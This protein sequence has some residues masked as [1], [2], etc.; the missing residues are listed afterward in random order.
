MNRFQKMFVNMLARS[1]AAAAG[2]RQRLGSLM[3]ANSAVGTSVALLS[4]LGLLRLRVAELHKE[5]RGDGGG[6][7]LTTV[8]LAV[9][10]VLAV[11][12]VVAGVGV[13]IAAAL[14]KLG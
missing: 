13:A 2:T 1:A 8:L 14:G 7:A 12:A 4:L 3:A 5:E 6:N 9:G 11:G 10:G